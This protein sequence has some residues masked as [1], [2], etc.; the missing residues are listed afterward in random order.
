MTTATIEQINLANRMAI[1]LE[2]VPTVRM[3]EMTNDN[4]REWLKQQENCLELAQ[5]NKSD[6]IELL[7]EFEQEG[8]R[9]DY[10]PN[11]PW[12]A[13]FV[14]TDAW[15]PEVNERY[16]KIFDGN[17]EGLQNTAHRVMDEFNILQ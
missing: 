5:T 13:R 3:F 10:E 4:G 15:T 2:M 14:A 6:F 11:D 7:F 17:L 16:W 12:L 8:L 1:Q 9:N